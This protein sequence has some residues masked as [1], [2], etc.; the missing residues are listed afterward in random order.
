MNGIFLALPVGLDS[1]GGRGHDEEQGGLTDS[2]GMDMPVE[3]DGSVPNN[4]QLE[5]QHCPHPLTSQ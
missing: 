5:A 4:Q 3:L 1:S 2:A